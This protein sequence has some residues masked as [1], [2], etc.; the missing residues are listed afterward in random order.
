MFRIAVEGAGRARKSP[1]KP[2]WPA[3]TR[4]ARKQARSLLS[5]AGAKREKRLRYRD[6][7][8]ASAGV[9]ESKPCEDKR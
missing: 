7:V 4:L 5:E 8:S 3:R 1:E 9:R 6:G 2:D